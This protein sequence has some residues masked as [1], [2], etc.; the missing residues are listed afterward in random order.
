MPSLFF[1]ASGANLKGCG[2]VV[3]QIRDFSRVKKPGNLLDHHFLLNGPILEILDVLSR[4]VSLVLTFMIFCAITADYGR[5][6]DSNP[7]LGAQNDAKP[8]K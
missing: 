5:L 2:L 6:R 8:I 3:R 7:S 1:R 4:C